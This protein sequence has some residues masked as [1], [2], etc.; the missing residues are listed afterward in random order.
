MTQQFRNYY[1]W[2]FLCF[3]EDAHVTHHPHELEVYYSGELACNREKKLKRLPLEGR[4]FVFYFMCIFFRMRAV[5]RNIGYWVLHNEAV[6]DISYLLF[7][8]SSSTP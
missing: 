3:L 2:W 1:C 8:I 7:I 6:M 5:K 4:N